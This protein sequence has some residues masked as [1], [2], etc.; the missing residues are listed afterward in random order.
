MSFEEIDPVE[1]REFLERPLRLLICCRMFRKQ[2]FGNV[3]PVVDD[4]HR[5]TFEHGVPK[6]KA[7]GAR[8]SLMFRPA[9]GG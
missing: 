3:G 4:H 7:T 5:Q 9:T 1:G 8:I 6:G 2:V